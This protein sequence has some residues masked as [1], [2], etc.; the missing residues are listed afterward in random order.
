MVGQLF[1]FNLKINN[2]FF[3]LWHTLCIEQILFVLLN[4][5]ELVSNNFIFT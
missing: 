4:L 3:T 2:N 1:D 5:F